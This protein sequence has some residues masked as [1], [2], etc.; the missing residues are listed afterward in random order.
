MASLVEA[1]DGIPTE[2]FSIELHGGKTAIGHVMILDRSCYIWLGSHG[3]EPSM[4]ALATAIPTRFEA[5]PLS[6]TL[7]SNDEDDIGREM[8]Q[9]LA[10]RF[11][12][13]VFVSCNFAVSLLDKQR[14]DVDKRLVE[15][16][17]GYFSKELG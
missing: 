17:A 2:E 3:A 8:A 4:S 9:K 6:S 15:L 16:L 1:E 11:K 12:I 5:I 14:Q 10:Q 7:M 13:Q